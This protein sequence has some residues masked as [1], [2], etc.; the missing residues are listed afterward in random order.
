MGQKDDEQK[1]TA[2]L[3]ECAPP[4]PAS[5]PGRVSR[6]DHLSSPGPQWKKREVLSS[7][8]PSMLVEPPGEAINNRQQPP[9]TAHLLLCLR[10]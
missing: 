2:V 8:V 1:K 3:W 10:P 4:G 6:D 7:R 5:A 9:L